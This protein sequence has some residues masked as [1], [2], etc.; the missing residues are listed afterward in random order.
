[1]TGQVLLWYQLNFPFSSW[2]HFTI[3]LKLGFGN[4]SLVTPGEIN[5]VFGKGFF[6][7]LNQQLEDFGAVEVERDPSVE[8]LAVG[9]LSED[10]TSTPRCSNLE[11][12]IPESAAKTSG[13]LSE[14]SRI[15]KCNH[16]AGGKS[17]RFAKIE[18]VLIS[19]GEGNTLVEIQSSY[20]VDQDFDLT[21]NSNMDSWFNID[22]SV[23]V[24]FGNC[25]VEMGD[26]GLLLSGFKGGTNLSVKDMFTER[27]AEIHGDLAL[28]VSSQPVAF[29]GYK[30]SKL[31]AVS[32][33]SFAKGIG[34]GMQMGYA[35]T[36]SGFTEDSQSKNVVIGFHYTPVI[37]NVY[38]SNLLILTVQKLVQQWDK[39]VTMFR[40]GTVISYELLWPIF[41]QK[42][43]G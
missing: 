41:K 43:A 32:V 11:P 28:D 37:L 35:Q 16:I 21:P 17:S 39:V 10:D 29:G 24:L 23:A 12:Q 30:T 42:K 7:R 36:H 33:Y 40:A 31:L 5:F 3:H 14:I 8:L 27:L 34:S 4:P 19:D 2:E 9:I 22:D 25:Q 1:M 15:G 18:D 20:Y 6:E 13:L 26:F 38:S